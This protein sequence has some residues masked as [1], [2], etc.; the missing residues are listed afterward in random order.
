MKETYKLVKNI[1][2]CNKCKD[3]IESKSIH[4][5]EECKCEAVQLMVD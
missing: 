2:S 3:I 5:Y 1:I 4:D